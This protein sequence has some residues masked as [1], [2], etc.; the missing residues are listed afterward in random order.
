MRRFRRAFAAMLRVEI[1]VMLQYRAEILLW[2]IWGLVNPAVLYAMWIAAAASNPSKSI[3]GMDRGQLAAYYFVIMVIGQFTAAWDVYDMG[4]QIRSGAY[5]EMLLK[6]ILPMWRSVC[7][8]LAY[9]I[10][11]LVFVVP[12]WAVFVFLVRP[13]FNVTAWQVGV[14]LIAMIL[15]AALAYV[16]CYIIGLI[17]FWAPKLD[18]LG[19]LYFGMGLFLGGRFAP[20]PALPK[21]IWILATILPFRWM[22]AFPTELL[23]GRITSVREAMTGLLIQASW[24]GGSIIV[25]RFAWRAAVKR[26]SAVSG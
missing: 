26:Y 17:A 16:M 14:G 1:G 11:T 3:V 12:M 8:N 24:L 19:E 9:K 25:F 22:Y 21:P 20:I 2:S 5:S 15:G 6:P 7:N 13:T 23:V 18:A 10:T 4:H